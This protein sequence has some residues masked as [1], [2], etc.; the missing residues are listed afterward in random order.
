MNL[1]FCNSL[2]ELFFENCKQKHNK[3]HLIYI[4]KETSKQE[5]Y[6]WQQTK[7]EVLSLSNILF[8]QKGRVPS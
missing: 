2:P 3:Q 6:N 8:D 1:S 5:F 4:N 7:E